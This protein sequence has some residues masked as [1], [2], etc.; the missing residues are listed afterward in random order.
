[1][2]RLP[3]LAEITTRIRQS[4]NEK[5][6]LRRAI[7]RDNALDFKTINGVEGERVLQTVNVIPR[8]SKTAGE[9]STERHPPGDVSTASLQTGFNRSRR[10]LGLLT[11]SLLPVG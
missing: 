5:S 8:C 3:D 9:G 6:E 4:L 10:C 7:A 11:L 2:D 1:M